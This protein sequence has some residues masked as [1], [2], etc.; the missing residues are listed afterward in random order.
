MSGQANTTWQCPRCGYEDHVNDDLPPTTLYRPW[1]VRGRREVR[2]YV[3]SLGA[4]LQEWLLALFVDDH[5]NLLAV[6]TIARG[7]LATC[8]VNFSRIICRG[9]ALKAAGFILVHNHPSGDPRPSNDDIRVTCRLRHVSAELDMPLVAHL[10]VAG[11]DMM[12]IGGF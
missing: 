11:D 5:L 10:V 1:H 6:D 3:E 7:D 2:A 8:H 4:E 12:D 9:H